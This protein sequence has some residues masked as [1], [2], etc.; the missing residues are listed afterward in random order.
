[1]AFAIA[2]PPSLS[3]DSYAYVGHARLQVLYGRNP[4]VHQLTELGALGDATASFLKVD[5]TSVYGPVWTYIAAAIVSMLR[6]PGLWWQVV[7]MKLVAAASLIGTVLLGRKI[8]E[9]FAP[10]RGN[11][12]VLALGINPLF[13]I[14]GPGNAHSDL[15]MMALF[16]A[17]AWHVLKGR[18]LWGALALGL[19]AGIKLLPIAV[20]PWVILERSAGRGWDGALRRALIIGSLM[21]LPTIV[22][23]VP[24]WRGTAT[25]APFISRLQS[26]PPDP[27]KA[28]EVRSTGRPAPASRS[29]SRLASQVP[30]LI[31]YAALTVWLARRRIEGGWLDAWAVLSCCLIVWTM[32]VIFPWY[33]IWP[34]AVLL[35]RWDRPHTLASAICL[36]MAFSQSW[37]YSFLILHGSLGK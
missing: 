4:Y 23:F 29:R 28:T 1:M 24:F 21:L 18:P 33:I 31:V 34:W 37:Q 19:S 16:L 2:F 32:G 9:H 15:L 11:L 12:A 3:T 14:E 36:V 22:G 8:A 10:G 30:V 5:V 27:R 6:R 17:G 13:L 35:T 25:F 20:L 26:S 7:A